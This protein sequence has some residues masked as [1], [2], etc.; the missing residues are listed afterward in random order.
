MTLQDAIG[1]DLYETPVLG[2]HG[3]LK[4]RDQFS[5]PS[6]GFTYGFARL[7]GG[8]DVGYVRRTSNFDENLDSGIRVLFRLSFTP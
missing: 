4:R 5:F 3:F 1:R 6:V 8:L 2:P 7:R